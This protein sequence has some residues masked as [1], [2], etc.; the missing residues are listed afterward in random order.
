MNLTWLWCII[1]LMCCGIPVANNLFRIFASIFISEA[2][3]CI[4]WVWGVGLDINIIAISL[5]L[6]LQKL[7]IFLYALKTSK[8]HWNYLFFKYMMTFPWDISK[9]WCVLE[10]SFMPQISIFL[11]VGLWQFL[12]LGFS[13]SLNVSD[14]KYYF[15]E[16]YSFL[17]GFKKICSSKQS[18]RNLWIS[19][20]VYIFLHYHFLFGVF[21]PSLFLPSIN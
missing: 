4:F 7:S 21:V 5:F 12:P 8:Y 9:V 17:T 2:D 16:N 15:L 10:G 20:I 3:I 18:L 19:C 1:L 13:I 6:E 14:R 11:L